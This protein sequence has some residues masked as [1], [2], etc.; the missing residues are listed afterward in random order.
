MHVN[1]NNTGTFIADA[2]ACRTGC[3]LTTGCIRTPTR[4]QKNF[5]LIS[6]HN[7]MCD[8]FPATTPETTLVNSMP[9]EVILRS[10]RSA[11]MT[12]S[13][14]ST[15]QAIFIS[16]EP[17]PGRAATSRRLL[18]LAVTQSQPRSHGP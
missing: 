18:S 1:H 14:G 11:A 4:E 12:M 9:R 5:A 13:A 6:M 15:A 17:V 7:K 3:A 10:Q 8:A 16:P 2:H